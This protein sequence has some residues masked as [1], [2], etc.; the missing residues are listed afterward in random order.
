MN[1]IKDALKEIILGNQS[2]LPLSLIR[3]DIEIER[4][5]KKATVILG[6]RRSGKTSLLLEYISGLVKEG[7]DKNQVCHID[8]SDDRLLLINEEMPGIVADAYYEL[9]PDNHERK[10]YFLFDEI[11]YLDNWELLVNRLQNTENCEINITGSS[12]KLLLD[13]TSTVLGGRKMGW[14]LYCYSYREFLRAK[15]ETCENFFSREFK[16]SQPRLFDEY[17]EAGGF[18]ESLLFT[19]NNARQIFFQNTANDIIFRDIVLRHNVSKPE[20]LKTMVNVLSSMVGCLMTENKLYQR[21]SGMHVKLSKP[22]MSEYLD[23]IEESYAFSFVPIRSYNLAVQSTNG[24]KV[25]CADHALSNAISSLSSNNVG[26]K[27]EN[28]VFLHLKRQTDKIYYYKT[29]SGFE[30]DFAAGRDDSVLLVQISADI[31][32]SE[33]MEREERSLT[34]AM[35]EL[36]VNESFLVTLSEEKEIVREDSTIHV[37]PAWKYL[38]NQN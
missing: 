36:N 18:P 17:L 19:T 34:E 10:V 6:V 2:E 25:Y 9:F 38:L 20:A 11:Q 4:I 16:D 3:R 5:A 29:K 28:I 33:T 37:I 22:T 15:G 13:E 12:S 35:K 8:F 1:A 32:L 26:Q 23:Y 21:L 7:L 27:L 24:K 14:N 31:S 30:V